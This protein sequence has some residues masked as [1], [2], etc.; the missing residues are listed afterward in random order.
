M[1]VDRK[2][3]PSLK[4][5]APKLFMMVE[6]KRGHVQLVVFMVNSGGGHTEVGV[7]PNVLHRDRPVMACRVSKSLE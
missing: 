7:H 3:I 5:T 6:L 1:V 4:K 2:G